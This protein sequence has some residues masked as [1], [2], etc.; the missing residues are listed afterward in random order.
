MAH[1]GRGNLTITEHA[2]P[3]ISLSA[4][5][6]VIIPA[7]NEEAAIGGVVR[8]VLAAGSGQIIQCIV[9]DNRSTDSTAKR[10]LSGGAV[11][12]SE[13]DR[14][15][16]AAC[17]AGI[18]ALVPDVEIVV[19]LDGDG[20]DSPADLPKII[21]PILSGS[22]DL[23]IGSRA[24]G[25]M[26]QGA[27]SVPQRFGNWLA[28]MLIRWFW[29]VRFTDLGPFRAITRKGLD[30]LDMRDRDFGWTVEMQ[31]KAARQGLRCAEVPVDYGRR[32]GKSKISGTVRGVI[33]AGSKI[34][35]VLAREALRARGGSRAGRALLA[36]RR[37]L[38]MPR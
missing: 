26:E 29:G 20:S 18:A 34:L 33:L 9:V 10:A 4:R 12:V 28:P 15:Y 19:F 25:S 1:L 36:K 38:A 14:G 27:M 30:A 31:I 16:G 8:S 7:L 32:L 23:V 37:M 13:P 5:I 24:L 22:A 11:V 21:A 17:L 35:Y 2:G 3:G 6:G